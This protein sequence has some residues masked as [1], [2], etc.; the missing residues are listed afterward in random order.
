VTFFKEEWERAFAS[1]QKKIDDLTSIVAERF[2]DSEEVASGEMFVFLFNK[3]KKDPTTKE[4]CRSLRR[5]QD[6]KVRAFHPAGK[7]K[8]QST[9]QLILMGIGRSAY[10]LDLPRILGGHDGKMRYL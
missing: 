2:N 5:P 7:K 4:G 9:S 10:S 1:T 3:K 8:G 6:A